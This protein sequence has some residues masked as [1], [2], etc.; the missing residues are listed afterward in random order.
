MSASH[1]WKLQGCSRIG[2]PIEESAN[3]Q[4][5]NSIVD[6]L[7]GQVHINLYFS[8][9]K[10]RG[11]LGELIARSGVCW[12]PEGKTIIR[13]TERIITKPPIFGEVNDPL[14]RFWEIDTLGIQERLA[15][16]LPSFP[17][18]CGLYLQIWIP[19]EDCPKFSS[20]EEF[21]S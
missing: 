12:P 14:K 6:V 20:L 7:I 11:N 13:K 4:N 1:Y 3:F 18:S 2:G 10:V 5:R 15:T 16:W 17:K 19:P 8:K 9:C 21:G